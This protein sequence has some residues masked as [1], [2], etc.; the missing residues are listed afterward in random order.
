MILETQQEFPG[1][2]CQLGGEVGSRPRAKQRPPAPAEQVTPGSSQTLLPSHS[3]QLRCL[4]V[5]GWR[6][7]ADRRRE[8]S[9][10]WLWTSSWHCQKSVKPVASH[11]AKTPSGDCCHLQEN[12]IMETEMLWLEGSNSPEGFPSLSWRSVL[13]REPDQQ[14]L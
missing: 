13:V 6:E 5:P 2:C 10:S 4:P 14:A 3:C 1:R 12:E 7:A 9:A 8:A 11:R